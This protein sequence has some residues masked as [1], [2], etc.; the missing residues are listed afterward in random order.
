MTIYETLGVRRVINASATLTRLGGSLMPSP[1]VAAMAEA[2]GAFIDLPELQRKVGAR[3][4]ELTHNEAAFVSSGA[5]AGITAS[6]AACI[7]GTD[8]QLIDVFPYLEGVEKTEVIVWHSQRNGYDYA[9]RQTGARLVTIGPE[10]GELEEAISTRTACI[11]WFAGEHYARDAMPIEEVVEIAHARDI[12]VI[13]DAAAQIPPISNLWHF[14]RDVGVDIAIFSGGKGLRGPQSSGLVLGRAD[15]IEACRAN[16][17]PN[18][19]IGR[20]MKVGKEEL[21]G[22]LAAVEWSLAQD[23]AAVIAGYEQSVQLW[24][25]GISGI[26]GVQAERGYPSEAGQPHG[27]AIVHIGPRCRLTRDQVVEALWDQDPRIAVAA[28]GSDAIG[29]NPQTLQTGEDQIVLDALRKVL[30]NPR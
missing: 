13:V 3:I 28:I 21:A 29:L 12:P 1:V 22:L 15:L 4:A 9:A 23:E 5:A 2:S 6:V 8:P 27:R 26:P 11:L 10:E 30:A 14:T 24:L 17:S 18:Q 25:D 7:A 19:T 16:S 20:P